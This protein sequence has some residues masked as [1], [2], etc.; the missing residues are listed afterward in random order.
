MS[1]T[2]STELRSAAG[3][4]VGDEYYVRLEQVGLEEATATV[5][6]LADFVDELVGVDPCLPQDDV[7]DP[8]PTTTTPPEQQ[9][10]G[11]EEPLPRP[12]A[13]V[14]VSTNFLPICST[15]DGNNF[16]TQLRV[17][18]SH[19]NEPY[20]LRLPGGKELQRRVIDVPVAGSVALEGAAGVRLDWPVVGSGSFS[21]NGS[22]LTSAGRGAGPAIRRDGNALLWDT[23]ATGVLQYSFASRCELIDVVVFADDDGN[24]ADCR[25]ICFF[26]GLVDVEDIKKP[27][28]GEDD[29]ERVDNLRQVYCVEGHGRPGDPPEV[30]PPWVTGRIQWRCVCSNEHSHYTYSNE[31]TQ[32]DIEKGE[33]RFPGIYKDSFGGYVKCGDEN[34]SEYL[35]DPEFYF[36]KCCKYPSI[37]LPRCKNVYRK[38]SAK[39]DIDPEI[40]KQYLDAYGEN[41]V[42]FIA[43]SPP[44][45]DCGYTRFW[46][47]IDAKNCCEDV[48]PLEWDPDYSPHVVPALF[49]VMRGK[50]PYHIKIRGENFSLAK[51]MLVR[52]IDDTDGWFRVY[53]MEADWCGTATITV[54]D[55]CGQQLEK[56][57]RTPEGDWAL[58]DVALQSRVEGG[59]GAACGWE[60]VSSCA[61]PWT[62]CYL[63]EPGANGDC[64]QYYG[65][66]LS[67]A[68]EFMDGIE[69]ENGEYKVVDTGCQGWRNCTSMV[70][71]SGSSCTLTDPVSGLPFTAGIPGHC[72]WDGTRI[73]TFQSA[74]YKW[75]CP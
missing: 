54:T 17:I 4:I 41:G 6:E 23:P 53:L 25:A 71:W 9:E 46:Q 26:H 42:N 67:R 38:N 68:S 13:E 63:T 44:D 50:A 39:S 30:K 59:T 32:K 11:S 28:L 12:L 52:D 7:G 61:G 34:E 45:G 73:Y 70:T 40:K 55:E 14:L 66:G 24:L 43:V 33:H 15:D 75:V 64:Y 36:D 22:V 72:Y 27:D 51:D 58:D 19:M 60:L 8:E 20:T 1:S 3:A 62:Y 21:W 10:P 69:N 16:F 2:L 49:H 18:R 29:A 74:R 5:D 37:V 35:Y 31:P 65:G 56:T 48:E 57:V 47:D